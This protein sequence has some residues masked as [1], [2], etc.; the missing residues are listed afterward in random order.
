MEGA[1][2]WSTHRQYVQ[3]V[4][5]S[6]LK[7]TDSRQCTYFKDLATPSLWSGD[8]SPLDPVVVERK[9]HQATQGK[10]GRNRGNGGF[11]CLWQAMTVCQSS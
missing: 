1:S 5:G 3:G 8:G 7:R 9:D 10:D 4:V 11:I 2:N 6:G